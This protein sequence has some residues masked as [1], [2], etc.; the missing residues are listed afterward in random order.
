MSDGVVSALG[1]DGEVVSEVLG[2]IAE[3]LFGLSF[4]DVDGRLEIEAL[5]FF[6]GSTDG[7]VLDFPQEDRTMA[8]PRIDIRMFLFMFFSSKIFFKQ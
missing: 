2:E 1:R 4:P 7:L 8:R 3:L 6:D 5:L